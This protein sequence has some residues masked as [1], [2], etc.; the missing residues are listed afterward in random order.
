MK[1]TKILYL[2]FYLTFLF[3]IISCSE[4]DN[5]RIPSNFSSIN[6]DSLQL[7]KFLSNAT[8]YLE[9]NELDSL[10]LVI[11]PFSKIAH[12]SQND[13][14]IGKT[15]GILGYLKLVEN[16]NDSAFYYLNQSKEY[17]TK[18]F[19]SVNIAKSLTN[20]A[21]IQANQADY[22]GSEISAI[23]ALKYLENFKDV[24]FVS[25]IYNSLAISSR[26][27]SNYPEAIYWYEKA[28][29]SSTDSL[30][31][32][33]Y[34]N[35]IAVS[36]S[37]LGKYKKADSILS[38]LLHDSFVLR[39]TDLKS[40]VMDNL[41][42]AKWKQ[43][44]TRNLEND[45]QKA[46]K[47]R[48][49]NNDDWGQVASH[50][51][52]SEYFNER[53]PE[54][55]LFHAQK[56]YDI[57]TQLNSPDD[58]LEALQKL[59]SLEAPEMAKKYAITYTRLSDSLTRARYRAKD[60][61]AK[62]RYDSEK[63]RDENQLLKIQDSE[64]QVQLERQK[65]IKIIA[66]AGIIILGLAFLIF[67]LTQKSRIKRERL[68]ATY[69][70]E[71]KMS[72]KVHD[73]LSNDIYRFIIHFQ[74]FL[75]VNHSEK[76]NMMVEIENIY[77]KS[78][79]ISKDL[80]DFDTKNFNHEIKSLFETYQSDSVN[81]IYNLLEDGTWSRVSTDAKREVFRVLQE[82][83]TNMSK[84]SKASHVLIQFK[85]E[86]ERIE[87]IYR[88][89]GIGITENQIITKSGL[90]NTENRMESINGSII[91]ESNLGK[92]LISKITFPA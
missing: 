67:Y 75:S 1:S 56:M 26:K 55:S 16:Q 35:N 45:F 41:A 39:N 63:N 37:Y 34:I 79:Q 38:V 15:N 2:Y 23:E 51:H 81:V 76:E 57:A 44:S 82:L 73:I 65:N 19:D 54:K 18:S 84:H 30:N 17:F 70:S 4:K 8:S 88:D 71:V 86:N 85:D 80:H 13:F 83:M 40:K 47:I 7:R 87:I 53:I 48:E 91:F 92:G 78:R 33:I 6:N 27:N 22:S 72:K 12:Q 11:I 50:S 62:I 43:N 25:S 60:Q 49:G 74:N 66:I 90:A 24:D 5:Y 10:K 3:L 21:I 68:I 31:K 61:F 14:Y 29:E 52:L 46:L 32:N 20:M 28:I 36:Y 77:E 69:E 64:K 9:K 89:N 42:Y 58:R 59:I